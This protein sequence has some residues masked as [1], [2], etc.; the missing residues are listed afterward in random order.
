MAWEKGQSGNPRGRP[1]GSKQKL[2]ERFLRNLH[3]DWKANGAEAIAAVRENSPVEYVKLIASLLPRE[4]HVT[5]K[6]EHQHLHGRLSETNA[7]LEGV[8]SGGEDTSSEKS[9]EA[10][11]LSG[12]E[13][14]GSLSATEKII[15]DGREALRAV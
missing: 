4:G 15:A 9:I 11:H 6:I 13:V 7:F 1:R 14:S 2:S 5:G 8:F 3:Q 10:R 12:D